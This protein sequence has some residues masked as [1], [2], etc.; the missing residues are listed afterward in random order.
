MRPQALAELFECSVKSAIPEDE[1][2]VIWLLACCL[3]AQVTLD[4]CKARSTCFKRPM[5]TAELKYRSQPNPYFYSRSSDASRGEQNVELRRLI[6]PTHS[7]L[8]FFTH[9]G[10]RPALSDLIREIEISRFASPRAH[11]LGSTHLGMKS[12]CLINTGDPF[13]LD[14]YRYNPCRLLVRPYCTSPWFMRPHGEPGK[15]PKNWN[16]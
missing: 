6:H 9:L 10:L 15:S 4:A 1:C 7:D 13:S 3:E 8:V 16:L 5:C 2:Q 11:H 14:D 12:V